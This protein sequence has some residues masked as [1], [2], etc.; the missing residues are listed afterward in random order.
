MLWVF[1]SLHHI[2]LLLEDTSKRT[3]K[4]KLNFNSF[5]HLPQSEILGL[6]LLYL[7][8]V[9]GSYYSLFACPK[10]IKQ[11]QNKQNNNNN[12]T[13]NMHN[14]FEEW[15]VGMEVYGVHMDDLHLSLCSNKRKHH[16]HILWTSDSAER[17]IG[18]SFSSYPLNNPM[19]ELRHCTKWEAET[20]AKHLCNPQTRKK[21]S[22]VYSQARAPSHYLL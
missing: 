22:E 13:Q 9:L 6:F 21:Q 16:D 14:V 12:E 5:L 19:R 11:K 7:Y 3:Q 2:S 17:L 20:E 10:T 1:K 8:N 4:T 15:Q 18:H